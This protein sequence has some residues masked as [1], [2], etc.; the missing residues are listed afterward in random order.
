MKLRKIFPT[1]S[2]DLGEIEKKVK[3]WQPRALIPCDMGW[4]LDIHTSTMKRWGKQI[5]QR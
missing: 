4:G 2:S 5:R 1:K 3:P